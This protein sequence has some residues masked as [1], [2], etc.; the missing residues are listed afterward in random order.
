MP[1]WPGATGDVVTSTIWNGLPAFDVAADKTTDY[2]AA[3]GDE[4]Q[5]LIPMNS[6][7]AIKFRL[8]TDATYNFAVGTVITVLNK[9]A[10]TL[11]VDAVTSGTT[12]V[13][14][15]GGTLAAPTVARYKS[16]ACIKTAANTWY[17]V[18]GIA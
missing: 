8:P 2:T 3:S 7:S 16:A 15:A 17:V 18:G 13:L 14:S 5:K 11:T 6:G 9:G 12:T 1:T 10:G 4:Y